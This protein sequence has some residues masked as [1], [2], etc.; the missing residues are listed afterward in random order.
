MPTAARVPQR[1]PHRPVGR[2]LAS[3]PDRRNVAA[4]RRRPTRSCGSATRTRVLVR[5]CTVGVSV[6][7]YYDSSTAQ[8]LTRDPLEA[9]TGA[10]YGYSGADPLDNADPSGLSFWGDVSDWT[11]SFGDTIT[12]GGTEQIRRLINYEV[13]GDMNDMVDHCSVFYQWGGYGGAIAASGLGAEDA[14]AGARAWWA[15]LRA[16]DDTGA[17]GRGLTPNQ[18]NQA[19]FRNQ[20]PKGIVRIDTPKVPGEQLHATFDDG[21]ALNVDG[22]W[23]HG[24]V[25]LTNAQRAWLSDNG[26][27]VP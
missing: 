26:W 20:A 22:S 21:S 27:T 11:A 5:G 14:A 7:R 1:V 6:A 18:M 24:G 13:N 3:G 25:T 15:R 8:V 23:K 17:L 4:G 2:K 16:M 9:L 12:F 10:P 19:I